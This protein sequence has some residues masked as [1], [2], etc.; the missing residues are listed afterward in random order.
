MAYT[1]TLIVLYIDFLCLRTFSRFLQNP[2]VSPP[3]KK[4]SQFSESGAESLSASVLCYIQTVKLESLKTLNK[5]LNPAEKP[6]MAGK[7]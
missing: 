3:S 1:Y 2:E 4:S 6:Y 7:L 5:F